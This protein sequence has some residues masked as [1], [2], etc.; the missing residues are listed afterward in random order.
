MKK[1]QTRRNTEKTRNKRNNKKEKNTK[2][3]RNNRNKRNNINNR[4]KHNKSKSMSKKNKNFSQRKYNG[5]RLLG[6]GT[7][8]VYY[9]IPALPCKPGTQEKEGIDY[10]SS[11]KYVSK[12]FQTV[13]EH[14]EEY[15]V[16]ERI[17]DGGLTMAEMEPY[18]LLPVDQCEVNKEVVN[19]DEP[20]TT[21]EWKTNG[22]GEYYNYD[23]KDFRYNNVGNVNPIL[24][25]N[26]GIPTE[27]QLERP[28]HNS[29]AR[30][31]DRTYERAGEL[32]YPWEYVDRSRVKLLMQR[33]PGPD[34]NIIGRF[35]SNMIPPKKTNWSKII[36]YPIVMYCI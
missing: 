32:G 28:V 14:K 13:E 29:D 5:G 27:E 10:A 25:K 2:N 18:F 4:K 30:A 35:Y 16:M 15:S 9:G 31:A 1:K 11:T 22:K 12:L 19:R 21:D 3:S 8:G 24:K 26:L 34:G 7:Y 6:K 23:Y 20:Y 17:I 33:V 36:I